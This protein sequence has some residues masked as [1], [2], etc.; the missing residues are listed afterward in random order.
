MSATIQKLWK[1]LLIL[2]LTSLVVFI[3]YSDE[4]KNEKLRDDDIPIVFYKEAYLDYRYSPPRI[5]VFSI[6]PCLHSQSTLLIKIGSKFLKL[7]GEPLEGECPWA[8]APTCYYNSYIFETSVTDSD[9]RISENISIILQNKNSDVPLKVIHPKTKEG[10]TVC[11]QPVYLYSQFQ[12]IILFIESWRNQ[13]A[14]HFIVYFHS[15]TNEVWMVLDHY[16]RLG[17][18]TIKPWP[19]FGDV[20]ARYPEINS[21]VYRIGHTM[22]ANLCILKMNTTL[23]TIV[24]FDEIIVPTTGSPNILESS[25]Q[26][27]KEAKVGALEFK[28]TRLQLDLNSEKTGFERKSLEN[29]ILLEKSGPVKLVFNTSSVGITL[30][31]SI[32]KFIN[33]SLKTIEVSIGLLLHYRYNGGQEAM[34]NKNTNFKIF[35]KNFEAHIRNIDT[36]TKSIFQEKR[37]LYEPR[38][39]LE[40]NECIEEMRQ[41]LV[42]RST[43]VNCKSRMEKLVSN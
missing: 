21:Q 1:T 19:K 18:L 27:L 30:T 15:S 14:T 40:L 3:F 26:S 13:G 36:V 35:E 42:C 25:R 9:F 16:Q 11:V 41:S 8:W 2:A 22:A 12:N 29:P 24:D 34:R 33:S 32:K 7:S 28:H 38:I 4:K 6:N 5:R 17:I 31:H 10:L 37:N 20:P 43:V 39:I 23:G